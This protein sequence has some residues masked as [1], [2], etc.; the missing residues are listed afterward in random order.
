MASSKYNFNTNTSGREILFQKV[1]KEIV[2]VIEP[3]KMTSDV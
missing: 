2:E 3:Q 1:E